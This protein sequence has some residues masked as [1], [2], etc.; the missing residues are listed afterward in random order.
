MSKAK[1]ELPIKIKTSKTKKIFFIRISNVS[2]VC[3]CRLLYG[4]CLL[5]LAVYFFVHVVPYAVLVYVPG[6]PVVKSAA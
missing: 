5:T 3:L 2:K 1:A 4:G 6:V